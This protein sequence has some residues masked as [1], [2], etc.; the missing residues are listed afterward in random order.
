MDQPSGLEHPISPA[1]LEAELA[2]QVAHLEC[3]LTTSRVIGA[4]TGIL[5]SQRNLAY[6]DAFAWLCA[7][8]QRTNRKVRDLSQQVVDFG[9]VLHGDS[10]PGNSRGAEPR[11]HE[12]TKTS[13]ARPVD[14]GGHRAESPSGGTVDTGT[15]VPSSKPPSDLPGSQR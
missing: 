15:Q 3:A 2:S 13:T 1:A 5:M 6:D 9:V 8:S 4:A 12:V 11:L 10:G 7:A 14:V